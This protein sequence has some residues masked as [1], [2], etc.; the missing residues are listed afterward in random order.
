MVKTM[1]E[2]E[3][4]DGGPNTAK[5]VKIGADEA[6]VEK[7]CAPTEN[8]WPKNWTSQRMWTGVYWG[9]TPLVLNEWTL[10]H[11]P[12]TIDWYWVYQNLTTAKVK[13]AKGK[14]VQVEVMTDKSIADGLF[15]Q[16]EYDMYHNGCMWY[17]M[18]DWDD[19]AGRWVD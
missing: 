1:A 15:A 8:V 5:D 4:Q 10:W 13:N 3:T 12:W 11:R 2:A 9:L 19:E 14:T 7:D 16:L 17:W 18:V 6:H